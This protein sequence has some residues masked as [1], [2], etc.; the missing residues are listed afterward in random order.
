MLLF[1]ADRRHHRFWDILKHRGQC[2]EHFRLTELVVRLVRTPPIFIFADQRPPTDLGPFGFIQRSVVL[3][4]MT[5]CLRGTSLQ[6]VP[7]LCPIQQ[8]SC[9]W[10]WHL[11]CPIL[12]VGNR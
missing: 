8:G 9:V 12:L 7:V 5:S 6:L 11:A 10:Q 3:L 1:F 4:P 2:R